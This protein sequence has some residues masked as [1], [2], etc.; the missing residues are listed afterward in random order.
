MGLPEKVQAVLSENGLGV[1]VRNE[2]YVSLLGPEL[3]QPGKRLVDLG[4]GLSPFGPAC[5]AHGMEVILIDDYGGGG[6]IDLDKTSQ[7]IPLLDV[8]EKK[9]GIR[10]IREDFLENPLPLPDASVDAVTSFHSLEHWHHSPRKLFR[11]IIRV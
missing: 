2:F 9:F 6:G 7:P 11:E 10:I 3:L 8:F 4:A 5:A 1:D